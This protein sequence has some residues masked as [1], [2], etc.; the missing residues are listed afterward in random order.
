LHTQ[1]FGT[2]VRTEKF[3]RRHKKVYDMLPLHNIYI[4]VTVPGL[5]LVVH[6]VYV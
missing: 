2:Y 6:N 1:D 5:L 4:W 3:C